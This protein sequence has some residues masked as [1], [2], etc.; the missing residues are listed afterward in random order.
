MENIYKV[1][2]SSRGKC[3]F[4]LA[5]LVHVHIARVCLCIYKW[6]EVWDV[7]R[8]KQNP[9]SLRVVDLVHTGLLNIRWYIFWNVKS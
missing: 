9:N 3:C 1:F 8:L 7:A 2:L 6:Y 4:I 5:M